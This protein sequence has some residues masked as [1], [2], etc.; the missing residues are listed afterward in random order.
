MN[1]PGY[2]LQDLLLIAARAPGRDAMDTHLLERA[3]LRLLST[4]AE[5]YVPA[6]LTEGVCPACVLPLGRCDQCDPGE[7]YCP[8][9]DIHWDHPGAAVSDPPRRA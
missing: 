8:V 6:A 1:V 2:A 5:D 3:A 4:R 9:C 7:P